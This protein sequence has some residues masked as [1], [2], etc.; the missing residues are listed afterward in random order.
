MLQLKR[1]YALS[2]LISALETTSI[3]TAK[4]I[5]GFKQDKSIREECC[6]E[7]TLGLSDVFRWSHLWWWWF[8][9]FAFTSALIILTSFSVFLLSSHM[10]CFMLTSSH[11][12]RRSRSDA[13]VAFVIS[14]ALL[15]CVCSSHFGE[16]SR[17][18]RSPFACYV[19]IDE[20][21]LVLIAMSW[22]LH[23][24]LFCCASH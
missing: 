14:R 4:T 6:Q 15:L 18:Q 22:M 19:Q 20:A 24:L 3:L 21:V 9:F 13:A 1:I 5:C 7:Y 17:F 8:F 11:I 12:K 23:L 2:R 10:A 16:I